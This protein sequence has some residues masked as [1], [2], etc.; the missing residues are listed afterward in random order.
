LTR[1][2]RTPSSPLWPRLKSAAWRQLKARG[3]HLHREPQAG[4]DL[5][6]PTSVEV[7]ASRALLRELLTRLEID[8]VLDVG[9]H[10]GGYGQL[11]RSIGYEGLIVSFEPAKEPFAVLEGRSREDGNWRAHR[12]ALGERAERLP[13]HLTSERNFSSFLPPSASA[14]RWFPGGV[15]VER[16]EAVEVVPLDDVLEQAIA[17]ARPRR[18][19]LKVDTQGFDLQV[20]RG[21]ARS[22]PLILGLQIELS[23]SPLYEGQPPLEEALAETRQMGFE[24]VHMMSVARD[25]ELGIIELD[26]LM[27]RRS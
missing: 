20:L 26:C 11:L 9:G 7:A 24:P 5:R 25:P 2:S 10:E 1:T 22:L 17:P 18:L 15:D 13:L 19:F 3:L 4:A 6:N 16:E 21:A 23:V 27:R 14:R 8:C 12:T